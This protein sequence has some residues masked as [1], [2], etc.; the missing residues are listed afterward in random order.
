VTPV[1]LVKSGGEAAVPEWR[2]CFAEAGANVDV[3]W[4]DDA[5]VDPTAVRYVLAWDPEA[6]RLAGYPNLRVIFGSG[7]GVD[8]IVNDPALP[9]HLPLVRMTTAGAAQRMGEF[10]VWA[11]LS[12][13]K[14]ARRIGIRQAA[15]KW[16]H[17]DAETTAPETTV[18]IMGLGH[19]GTAAA[20][21]LS[22]IG[23]PVIGWT[24]TP[25]HIPGVRGFVGEAE[26]DA[27]LADT[28]ILV[29]LLPSTAE[30]RGILAKPLLERL[31]RG[32]ALINVGRGSHQNTAD[33]IAALDSGRL[34][35]AVLDVFEQEPLPAEHPAWTH[36]KILVTPHV[37]SLP[38]RG[39]RAAYVAHL[40]AAHERGETLPNRYDHDRGY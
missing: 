3:R 33:I 23:F 17:F 21:M 2:R 36:P 38:P 40:I 35:G 25:K 32:A 26:R 19:M 37:A 30:T 24:R 18:G 15:R 5:S 28:R 6:G 20:R 34:S 29:C 22:G 11:A 16:E 27:F 1:L 14:G 10:V 31:P 12:L 13:L 4:W 9:R 39:E 8:F 7:A